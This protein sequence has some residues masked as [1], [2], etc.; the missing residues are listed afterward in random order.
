MALSSVA[1]P[2]I[3]VLN[4]VTSGDRSSLLSL[5]GVPTAYSYCRAVEIA[6]GVYLRLLLLLLLLL[7]QIGRAHV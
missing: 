2:S 6:R 1:R 5:L 4:S 7:L 3:T